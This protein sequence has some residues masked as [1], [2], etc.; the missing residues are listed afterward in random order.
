MIKYLRTITLFILFLNLFF[1]CSVNRQLFLNSSEKQIKLRLNKKEIDWTISP[2]VNPD[3][4]LVFCKEKFN[5]VSFISDKDSITF[6][7]TNNDTIKLSILLNNTDTAYTEI[8]GYK[9]IPKSID[10]SERLYYLSKLWSEIRYNFINLDTLSI[11]TDAKYKECIIDAINAKNDYEYYRTLKK[12]TAFFHD[13]HTSVSDNFQFHNFMDYVPISFMDFEHKIYISSVRNNQSN[14]STWLG[15]ELIE[16]E[17]IPTVRYLETEIFPYISASTEQHLWMQATSELSYDLKTKDFIG[18][19]KKL[20]GSIEKITLA[21]NGEETRKKD[22]QYWRPRST[23]TKKKLAQL[24][25]LENNIALIRYNNFHPEKESINEFNNIISQITKANGV[26]IDLRN[27]GGGSTKVGWNLQ[28]YLTKD[29]FFLNY[30]WES[31][32][33]DG[34]KKANGNWIKEYEDFYLERATRF[35]NSDTIW[36]EDS[37]QRI[38]CPVILLIGRYTFSAAEDFLINIYETKDRPLIIG[39]E[40]GGSTGSPLVIDNLPGGGYARICTRRVLFPISKIPFINKGIIPDIIV[41]ET[42]NDYLNS[43]DPILDKAINE[44]N[45]KNSFKKVTN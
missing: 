32:I 8:I 30:S 23:G 5:T 20:D 45:K 3:R 37:I 36:I 13:G 26:I 27:N 18:K 24:E 9:D 4:F 17:G 22:D 16:I 6:R 35:V 14:D 41:K 15:A 44:I 25:W 2:Q 10:V 29:P 40:T 42:I 34:V 43:F 11:D 12:F 39:E 7:I 1:S 28:K 38:Q 33:N 21:R 31:R 19:I